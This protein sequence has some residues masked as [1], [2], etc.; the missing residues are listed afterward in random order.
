MER[1]I[2]PIC[3]NRS[4]KTRGESFWKSEI[5]VRGLPHHSLLGAG[6]AFP[7]VVALV[8]L[9]ANVDTRTV[10]RGIL[11]VCADCDIRYSSLGNVLSLSPLHV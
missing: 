4:G 6:S 5:A 9:A 11:D 3:R 1:K 7:S 8:P 2:V 10:L